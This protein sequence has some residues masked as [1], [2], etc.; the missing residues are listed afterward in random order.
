MIAGK[1]AGRHGEAKNSWLT[2]TAAWNFVAVSQHI[3]GIRPHWEG[4]EI[5]PCVPA[6]WQEFT[7]ER[8]F[9]GGRYSIHFLNKNRTARRGVESIFL[10]GER[11]DSS[12]IPAGL[13]GET[14]H[15]EVVL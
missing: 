8:L 4:L 7:V 13:E 1:E 3:L 10:D 15:V 2:G 6:S 11:L 12:I 14:H 9:R 5:D